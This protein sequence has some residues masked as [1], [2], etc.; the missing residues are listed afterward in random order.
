MPQKDPCKP[1][2][3]KIQECLRANNYQESACEEAIESMRQCCV[4]WG[5][6]SFVCNG[7]KTEKPRKGIK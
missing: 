4:K 2:A 3:C 1:F 5:T 7:I 6:E